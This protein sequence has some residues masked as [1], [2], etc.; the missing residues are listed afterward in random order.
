MLAGTAL[1]LTTACTGERRTPN[2]VLVSLDTTR[3]DHCSL[4]GYE[5]P[6]TPELE[7]LARSG[8]MVEIAYAASATTGPSHAT[9]FTGLYPPTHGVRKNGAVLDEELST[10]A[11]ILAAT[12]FQTAGFIGSYVLHSQFGYG[13]GF[14]I[15]DDRFEKRE[16]SGEGE[17]WN[18]EFPFDRRADFT[19]DRAL[20]W[21]RDGRRG[22]GPFFLFVHYFDP[23]APYAPPKGFDGRFSRTEDA[24]GPADRGETLQDVLDDY[25]EEILFTDT[26]M[27]RLLDSLDELEDD[28]ETVIVVTADHGEGLMDHGHLHHG[29]HLYEEAVRVPLV[30]R[31]PRVGSPGSRLT[32]PIH[33]VDL[34]PTI[35][36]LL[37]VEPPKEELPGL[38]LTEPLDVGGFP[39]PARSIFL[40]RRH[41]DGTEPVA[42][43]R[44]SGEGYGLRKGN[45]KYIQMPEE[46]RRELYFLGEDPGETV[47]LAGERPERVRQ[48]SRALASWLEETERGS[49]ADLRIDPEDRRRLEALGYTN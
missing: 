14:E 33:H 44:V 3:S 17:S 45:W 29:I 20:S 39:N 4:Y 18:F 12:G 15:Y 42:G 35:L 49:P 6:T 27:G 25:D 22:K 40:F 8:T 30:I 13:Q 7:Q 19:T 48:M 31:D 9:L 2:L 10:L 24:E 37:A 23:H 32:G 46:E 11:E 41:Y 34:L 47:N 28:R 5:R 16:I 43:I 1:L 38:V 26:Q 21:L 36:D